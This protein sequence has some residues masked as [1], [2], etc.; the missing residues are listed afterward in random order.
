M[1]KFRI[2]CPDC[3]AVVITAEPQSAVW[4]LCPGCKQH[5]WDV[6]D[7]LMAEIYV[8]EKQS[9]TNHTAHPDN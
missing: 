5:I 9:L 2:T 8:Q 4:E 6:Y 1:T 7:V 3:G